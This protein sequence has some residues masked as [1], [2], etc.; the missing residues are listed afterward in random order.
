MTYS[1]YSGEYC[2]SECHTRPVVVSHGTLSDIQ[3]M[4]GLVLVLV[5]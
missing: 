5:P 2:Y 3:G 4:Q 1:A